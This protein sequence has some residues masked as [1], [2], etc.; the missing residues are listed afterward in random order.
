MFRLSHRSQATTI[1][2]MES[3][4]TRTV[5]KDQAQPNW[6]QIGFFVLAVGTMLMGLWLAT[7]LFARPWLDNNSSPEDLRNYLWS[8][9]V[10]GA[11][12]VAVWGLAFAGVRTWAL[13]RQANVAVIDAKLNAQRHQSEAFATAIEQLGGNNFAVRL[14]AVYALEALAQSNRALHG[15]IF[16]TLCAYIRENAPMPS[17]ET[18][19]KTIEKQTSFLPEQK[20]I[21]IPE[22]APLVQAILTAIGQRDPTCDPNDFHLDLQSTDLRRCDLSGGHF[23]KANFMLAHLDYANLS[24]VD[25]E[26]AD[27][28][29]ANIRCASLQGL[30][31]NDKTNVLDT[32][33]FECTNIPASSKNDFRATVKNAPTARWPAD[34]APGAWDRSA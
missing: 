26:G 31:F 10:V 5:D 19:A 17:G 27:M 4:Q 34:D 20:W 22:P 11:G 14:G 29:S 12:V 6:V 8:W 30:L 21:P 15:P 9:G 23:S 18:Q 7:G 3:N 1:A 24:K 25:F 2:G 16:K 32:L 13:D 33:F 28:S